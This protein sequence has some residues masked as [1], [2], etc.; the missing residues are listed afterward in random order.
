[1]RPLKIKMT[2][3]GPYKLTEIIDF[4]EL[5][6][7]R[8]FVISGKTGAGKTSIFDAICFALYGEASGQDRNDSKMLRSQFAEDELYTSVELEFELKKHTYRIFRQLSHVKSGNKSATGER[9]EFFE[10]TDGMEKPMCE[11]FIVSQVNEK[12]LQLLG[13]SKEQFNQIVML[14]QG[15][16]RKLLTSDTENKEEILRRIFK[17][18]L[19]KNVESML[20]ERRKQSQSIFEQQIKERGI[21]INSL[22]T[23]LPMREGTQLT[24]VFGQDL[25]NTFQILEALEEEISYYKEEVSSNELRL[26]RETKK[27]QDITAQYHYAEAIHQRFDILEQKKAYKEKLESQLPEMASM[28][29]KIELAEKTDRIQLVE[30][31]QMEAKKDFLS[32]NKALEKAK[33]TDLQAE[34]R[35]ENAKQEY[36]EEEKKQ[37]ELER[38]SKQLE[39][40]QE[41]LPIVKDLNQKQIQIKDLEHKSGH[42]QQTFNTLE[43]QMQTK[44]TE[45]NK[46]IEEIK[47]LET[48]LRSLP[49]KQEML[50]EKRE[51]SVVLT[52]YMKLQQ[53]VFEAREEVALNKSNFE[54]A[55]HHY[56]TIEKRWIEGQASILAAHL[57]D[58]E[59]CPVCGSKEH[60]SKTK[61]TEE[62][63]SKQVLDTARKAKEEALDE[64]RK[65]EAKVENFSLQMNEKQ[66]VV[67]QY[68]FHL[69]NI[70]EEYDHFVQLG[71]SLKK[72]VELLREKQ[73]HLDQLKPL[74][75]ELN[76]WLDQKTKEKEK[77]RSDL[78][79]VNTKHAT[80]KAL[81][82]QSIVNIPEEVRSLALLEERMKQIQ[83][84]KS[85]LEL[86]WKT[87][88]E[89][90]EQTKIKRSEVGAHLVN[91]ET[92]VQ[93]TQGKLEKVNHQFSQSLVEAGFLQE[94]DYQKAKMTK[95]IRLQLTKQMED[96]KSNLTTVSKQIDE[97]EGELKDKKREDLNEIQNSLDELKKLVEQIRTQYYEVQ[98]Y[99]ERAEEGKQNILSV[100]EKVQQAEDRYQLIKDLY[101]V[102]RGDNVKKISFERY[103]QIEFLEQIIQMANG[104]LQKLSNGQFQLLR[105]D[106]LEKRGRQSGLGLDVYDH[107]TG[108]L[109]D[110][111]TM[112]GGEKFNASLCLALG[113]ADVIQTYEGGISIETMFIDEG[114]GSLDEESLTKAID[115]LIEL[116]KSGRM[117]GVISHVQ[118]LKQAIPAVL[119]V[120]KTKEGTSSTAFDIR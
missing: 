2:A 87:V 41:W 97:L 100:S 31:N 88:Q 38:I 59:M 4:T 106:R 76:Q 66:Q 56:D 17:T 90:L 10:T 86:R 84:Q 34:K 7:H 112:S 5:D 20:N 85:A 62:I 99:T 43:K 53:A 23:A 27:L 15:E 16:F 63:P 113:M 115:T 105:S 83:S 11:R 98:N 77:I 14:P 33:I 1:M 39:H 37:P 78:N 19:Y 64:Y 22:K 69:E 55:Q 103:L 52:E 60:P 93:E 29:K 9:Y 118:E 13:I 45:R 111:K 92:Q 48:Q 119:D 24:E 44:Q 89:Q 91:A 67:I 114:F 116:Q 28:K 8:L 71:K 80:E 30:Q 102:I 108:Q 107:Y 65:V 70:K 21:Y 94:S 51:Q 40:L 95:E 3:F 36:Q 117:I 68:G 57:H 49:E 120:R 26:Q 6:E 110:V 50:A 35:L 42:L 61:N 109:R 32:K 18:G 82:E 81:L 101:D 74:L 104:R 72:E 46:V 96:W 47:T 79:E 25:Y 58:G 54:K 12:V 75:D 73:N